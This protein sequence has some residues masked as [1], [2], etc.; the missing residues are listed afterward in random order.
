MERGLRALGNKTITLLFASF[1]TS[2]LPL[3]QGGREW[4]DY[5]VNVVADA[6]YTL[7]VRCYPRKDACFH[8]EFDGEDKTGPIVTPDTGMTPEGRCTQ[9]EGQLP[10][11]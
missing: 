7:E 8:I 1:D 11:L 3:N 5:S 2:A 9:K 6:Y 4:L 10:A